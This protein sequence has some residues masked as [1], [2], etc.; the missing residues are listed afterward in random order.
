[1]MVQMICPTF[2]GLNDLHQ[3]PNASA[4]NLNILP[5]AMC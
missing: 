3:Q 1:M 4:G 5:K 2:L